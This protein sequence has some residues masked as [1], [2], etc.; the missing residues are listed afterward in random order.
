MRVYNHVPIC[1][2]FC[3]AAENPLVTFMVSVPSDQDLSVNARVQFGTPD[4]NVGNGFKTDTDS[5]VAPGSGLYVFFLKVMWPLRLTCKILLK[6]KSGFL[7][8]KP[9]KKP[10][11]SFLIF[12]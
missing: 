1:F 3:L 10:N 12:F 9:Q 11:M 6:C 4:L 8:A 7:Y 5:F 2:L